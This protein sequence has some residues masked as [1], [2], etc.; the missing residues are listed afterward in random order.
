MEANVV[1][2]ARSGATPLLNA[3]I[4]SQFA[5]RSVH[6]IVI[7]TTVIKSI[8]Q[9]LLEIRRCK[10]DYGRLAFSVAAAENWNKLPIDV[11]LSDTDSIFR[12]RLKTFLFETAFNDNNSI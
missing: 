10:T 9:P 5:K 8:R 2:A 12:K 11:Q 6:I 7:V 4:S 1:T 3:I